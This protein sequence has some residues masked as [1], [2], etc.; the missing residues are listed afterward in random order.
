[1]ALEKIVI[2]YGE[3]PAG[4]KEIFELCRGF[5]RAYTSFINVSNCA[6]RLDQTSA[7]K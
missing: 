1:M 4:I 6:V 7:G 3:A 5:E 2:G